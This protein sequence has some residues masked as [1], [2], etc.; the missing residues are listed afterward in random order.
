MSEHK[1]FEVGYCHTIANPKDGLCIFGG[2]A[3]KKTDAGK[4][5]LSL[6][7]PVVLISEITSNR[8]ELAEIIAKL[9]NENADRFFHSA[10]RTEP[11]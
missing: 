2:D 11:D 3:P 4:I 5:S 1:Y 6:R 10:A 7:A 8:E 9:L